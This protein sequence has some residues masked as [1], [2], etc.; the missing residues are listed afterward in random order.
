MST[1]PELCSCFGWTCYGALWVLQIFL[2]VS[3]KPSYCELWWEL[4]L[5]FLKQYVSCH[6][7]GTKQRKHCPTR[8]FK[9]HYYFLLLFSLTVVDIWLWRP[10]R[11]Y[12]LKPE[13]VF[14]LHGPFRY[15]EQRMHKTLTEILKKRW[16]KST[17]LLFSDR[18]SSKERQTQLSLCPLGASLSVH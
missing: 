5:E 12:W 18:K 8:F 3:C 2:F 14:I 17:F 10:E 13:S 15:L 16:V 4:V 7:S 6:F 9:D 11:N 1:L